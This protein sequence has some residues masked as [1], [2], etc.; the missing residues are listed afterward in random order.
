MS[1]S[2]RHVES[3]PEDDNPSSNPLSSSLNIVVSVPEAIEIKM[4]DASALADYE[5]WFFISSLLSSALIGFFVAYLQSKDGI[6]HSAG[7]LGCMTLFLLLLFAISVATALHKR[8]CLQK[9]GRSINL[10]ATNET[11]K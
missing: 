8:K 9:K 3:S 7:P 4:V 1:D 11:T 2:P 10:K 6:S 5:I